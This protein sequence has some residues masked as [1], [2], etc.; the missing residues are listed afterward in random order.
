MNLSRFLLL[1]TGLISIFSGPL[2]AQTV[3]QNVNMVSGTAVGEG[4]P[5]LQRQNEPSISVSTRNP[6]HLLAGANDYRLVDVPG[7]L[8]NN[9]ETGDVWLGVFRST[10]GGKTWQSAVLPGCPYPITACTSGPPSAVTGR[11]AAADATI[12]SAPNGMFHMNG[13]AFDRGK[14]ALGN[15][16]VASFIDDNNKENGNPFRYLGAVQ[17]DSGTSGQFLDKPWIATALSTSGRK[18]TIPGSGSVPAQTFDAYNVYIVYAKFVGNNS[19]SS[20]I[21]FSRSL[22]CGQTFSNPV[23]LSE[24]NSLN[25]GT[26]IAVNPAKEG[27][28]FVAWRRSASSSDTDAILVTK[29]TDEGRT[30]VGPAR[31]AVSFATNQFFDQPRIQPSNPNATYPQAF[32]SKAFPTMSVDGDGRVYLAWAQ[33]GLAPAPFSHNSR[34]VLAM[35]TDGLNFPASQIAVPDN[36]AG[37]GYQF[38][39]AMAFAGG[40]LMLTW[41][42]SRDSQVKYFYTSLGGGAY[43]EERRVLGNPTTAFNMPFVQD[44]S[45][46]PRLQTIDLRG[47]QGVNLDSFSA[48]NPARSLSVRISQYKFGTRTQT[49]NVIEQ[50]QFNPPNLPMFGRGTSSFIG[51]YNDVQGPAYLPAPGN[52]WVYNTTNPEFAVFHATWADNRNVQRPKNG[53][54]KAFT[55]VGQRSSGTMSLYDPSQQLPVC[56]AGQEGTRNQD[57]YTAVI[58]PGLLVN[59]LGTEKPL[60]TALQRTYAVWVQNTTNRARTFRLSFAPLPSNTSASFLSLINPALTPQ[61]TLDVTVPRRSSVSRTAFVLSALANASVTVLVTEIDNPNG[62]TFTGALLGTAVLNPDQAQPEIAQP[63]IAQP[64]IV[65]P[66]IAT[67]ET[68]NPSISQPEIA[69]PLAINAA[70]TNPEI[71]QP[72]IAQPEIVQPEIVQPEIAQPEIAQP[73][74]AQPEIA[75]PEIAAAD[76]AAGYTDTSFTIRNLGN[77]S[78]AYLTK[79]LSTGDL[80]PCDGS[81]KTPC[82]CTEAIKTNCVKLNLFLSKAYQNPVNRAC[83]LSFV[84]QNQLIANIANPELT[85]LS[86]TFTDTRAGIT[87]PN[88][89]NP[90]LALQPGEEAR[91]TIRSF[92]QSFDLSRFLTPVIQAQGPNSTEAK[93]PLTLAITTFRLPDAVAGR[94]YAHPI[95]VLEPQPNLAFVLSGGNI[96][97]GNPAFAMTLAAD[98]KSGILSGTP[99]QTGTYTFTIRASDKPVNYPARNAFA[100]LT[101]KVVEPLATPPTAGPLPAA[102]L[103]IPY[104]GQINVA[105]GTPPLTFA[106]FSGTLPTGLVLDPVTGKITGTPTEGGTFNFV[107]KVTDSS[108]S[109][110]TGQTCEPQFLNLSLTIGVDTTPPVVAAEVFAGTVGQNGWYTSAVSVRW[111]VSDPESGIKTGCPDVTGLTA[112]QTI[113]CTAEN[114]AGLKTTAS[115]DLKIDT[116]APV[117]TPQ[118]A[119]TLGA[120]GWYTSD[121]TVTWQTSDPESNIAVPCVATEIKTSTA[122]QTVTCTT[123][124]FAG[125]ETTSSVTLKVDLVGPLLTFTQAPPANAAGWNNTDVTFTFACSDIS[126]VAAVPAAVTLTAEGNPTSQLVSCTNGAGVTSTVTV[127]AKIDKTAPVITIT[128]PAEGSSYPPGGTFI[129]TYTCTDALSGVLPVNCT[130]PVPSGGTVTVTSSTTSFTVNAVDQAGNTASRTVNYGSQYTFLGF[131]SPLGPAG[132]FSGTQN[133]GRGVPLKFELRAGTEPV[134]RLDA[135][136]TITSYFTG[137]RNGNNPCPLTL[138]ATSFLL[139]NPTQGATGGSTFRVSGNTYTFNWDTSFGAPTRGCYTL[140]VQLNDGSAPKITSLELR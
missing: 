90:T 39:P 86:A 28:I 118:I 54:W 8:N 43:S 22:D 102:G 119:G 4:D 91:L 26:V 1:G 140:A 98:G 123:K 3:G 38:M 107:V 134:T 69:A 53:D 58:S 50:L 96:P 56:Q 65:N 126:G 21:M 9:E 100:V 46:L 10:D 31:V 14:N 36:H 136:T 129:A 66:L 61:P 18:C 131:Q 94:A 73:E 84:V 67:A 124:N 106:L 125:L 11:Q 37:G 99:T 70:I 7:L 127:A 111:N 6:L 82:T 15:I 30:W 110:L 29:S 80:K 27:E 77:T 71:V 16:F 57:I 62:S 17:V 76:I 133:F 85:P 93:A 83:Q 115:L 68:F 108:C 34:I 88:T 116:T 95:T 97:P 40:R 113:Q 60:S 51:D 32:R 12:R 64:E 42:D 44:D 122:G 79:L 112:S 35:S 132:T 135:V 24:S 78:A 104:E 114:K 105:G 74:I 41:Y 63:E 45:T 103:G 138:S 20:Q 121:V 5:F 25:Q 59:A 109:T 55:P 81:G 13:I 139:Y 117:V 47:I 48:S 120:N 23:K 52:K 92:P 2:S 33:R 87:S 75:Q 130:G 19:T 72:E 101:L 49:P 128:S 137:A 89:T